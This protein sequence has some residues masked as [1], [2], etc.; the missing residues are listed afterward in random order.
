MRPFRESRTPL[1]MLSRSES[2]HCT[3]LLTDRYVSSNNSSRALATERSDSGPLIAIQPSF[4]CGI[5][6]D[7]ESPLREKLRTPS[8]PIKLLMH[9]LGVNA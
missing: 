2:A 4:I 7:F 8:L 1:P 5:P 3:G 6:A 9:R